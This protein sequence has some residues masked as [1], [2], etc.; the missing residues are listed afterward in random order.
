MHTFSLRPAWRVT[1]GLMLSQSLSQASLSSAFTVNTLAAVMLSGQRELAGLAGMAVLSGAAL[2]AYP[3]GRLMERLGRRAGLTL[4]AVLGGVGAALAALA[5]VRGSFLAFLW[6]LVIMGVGRVALDQSRFAVAEVTLPAQRARAMSLV[7]WGATA[8]AVLGPLLAAPAGNMALALGLNTYAGPF[9]LTALG[10]L[11]VSLLICLALGVDWRALMM[12]ADARFSPASRAFAA[13]DDSRSDSF[14]QA[15]RLPP[16]RLALMA[17]A[18]GQAAMV[19]MMASVSVHMSDHSHDLFA[20]STVISVHVLGMYALSPLIG[21]LADRA[22]RYAVIGAG[23]AL[24][25]LGCVIT[26]LSLQTPLIALGEFFVG[27]GWSGCYLGGSALLAD[28][29]RGSARARLQGGS[30]AV[31]NFAS[32]FGSLG[33]GLLLATVGFPLLSA[34]GFVV[35]LTPLLLL[36]AMRLRSALPIAS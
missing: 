35:A 33:S 18:C 15:L 10:F 4:G 23:A 21:Q 8:G 7:V 17:M 31:V 13:S 12:A 6:G 14:A 20:I 28:A 24:L 27:L 36:S 22:G 32:A 3:V 11:I 9:A 26:P 19:L 16:V 5:L 29:L 25:M 1:A 34:V 2:G 30:D